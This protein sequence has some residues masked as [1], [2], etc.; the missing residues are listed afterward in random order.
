MKKSHIAIEY[1][2]KSAIV[3]LVAVM[4]IFGIPVVYP[5]IILAFLSIP[6]FCVVSAILFIILWITPFTKRDG[7]FKTKYIIVPAIPLGIIAAISLLIL[8]SI[9]VYN[10]IMYSSVAHEINKLV[11]NADE[12]LVYRKDYES[13]TTYPKG[14]LGSD[15]TQSSVFI[16]YDSMEIAF[17]FYDWSFKDTYVKY[18]FEPMDNENVEYIKS[19]GNYLYDGFSAPYIG[20]IYKPQSRANISYPGSL[21]FSYYQYG[22][23]YISRGSTI[24]LVII[25]SDGTMWISKMERTD[26]NLGDY[27]DGVSLIR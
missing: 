13:N 4:F 24:G 3:G 18:K 5:L 15:V 19:D 26:L 16:D 23:G 25:M 21:L 14:I 2:I 9:F 6:L 10:K 1:L 12:V 7:S 20:E 8:L 11:E 27:S 22:D 17:V